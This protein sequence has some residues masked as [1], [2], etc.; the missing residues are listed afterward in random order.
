MKDLLFFPLPP[1]PLLGTT[2][3]EL[4]QFGLLVAAGCAYAKREGLNASRFVLAAFASVSLFYLLWPADSAPQ[5]EMDRTLMHAMAAAVSGMMQ[6]GGTEAH[7]EGISVV[8]Q[9]KFTLARGCLGLSYVAMA[10]LCV[11]AYPL[12]WRRRLIGALGVAAGMVWLNAVRMVVLYHL[13]DLREAGAH[14]LFHRVGGGCFAATAL[15]LFCGI[16][17]AR[18]RVKAPPPEDVP[19]VP[20]LK[21]PALVGQ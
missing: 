19:D 10:A 5:R 16:L 2:G 15:L 6:L 17:S 11:M 13:W 21:P 9:M 3:T 20:A 1:P 18:P 7:V 8:A 12:P 14:G 4:L